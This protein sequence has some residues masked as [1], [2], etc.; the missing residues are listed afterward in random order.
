MRIVCTWRYNSIG[1]RRETRSGIGESYKQTIKK[2][3]TLTSY[4]DVGLKKCWKEKRWGT[5]IR[6]QKIKKWHAMWDRS[7]LERAHRRKQVAK[8]QDQ[9]KEN[10]SDKRSEPVMCL[11]WKLRLRWCVDHA[12]SLC[13]VLLKIIAE[14]LKNVCWE[15]RRIGYYGLVKWN[16]EEMVKYEDNNERGIISW[17]HRSRGYEWHAVSKKRQQEVEKIEQLGQD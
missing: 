6:Y 7:T 17:C 14:T 1:H 13:W 12:P 8:K 2:N 10:R 5:E 9:K 4:N 11:S 16:L 15:P 3:K